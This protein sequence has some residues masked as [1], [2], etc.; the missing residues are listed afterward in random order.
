MQ[1]F[2][3]YIEKKCT[4]WAS[5][6]K[7]MTKPIYPLWFPKGMNAHCFLLL[8]S[9][10]FINLFC[11][12]NWFVYSRIFI[13]KFPSLLFY[14]LFYLEGNS[15]ILLVLKRVEYFYFCF[16]NFKSKQKRAAVRPYKQVFTVPDSLFL[17]KKMWKSGLCTT[18]FWS[19]YLMLTQL[20][21]TMNLGLVFW[22][23]VCFPRC[24]FQH[25][26]LAYWSVS[27]KDYYTQVNS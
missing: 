7:E 16:C 19:K 20:K 22:A 14:G 21:G 17:F 9:P 8:F 1:F 12:V 4:L 10:K 6:G 25:V 13:W 2:A 3:L 15:H 27:K 24:G 5:H 11:S 23:T 18:H 26:P